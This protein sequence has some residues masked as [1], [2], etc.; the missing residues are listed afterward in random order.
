MITQTK[1]VYNKRKLKT[2]SV[3]LEF[4]EDVESSKD[5]GFRK[6]LLAVHSEFSGDVLKEILREIDPELTQDELRRLIRVKLR[7]IG[8]EI[9]LD[10]INIIDKNI[11][12]KRLS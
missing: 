6:R 2:K 11:K 1:Y 10:S 12:R 7:R 3:D 8:I 9:P 4:N 5:N